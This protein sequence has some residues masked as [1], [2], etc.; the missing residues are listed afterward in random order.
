VIFSVNFLE[1]ILP[2]KPTFTSPQKGCLFP[3]IILI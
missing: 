3:K 1:N 2:L